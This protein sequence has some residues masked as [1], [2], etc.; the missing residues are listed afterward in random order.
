MARLFI[1]RFLRQSENAK[2][3]PGPGEGICR[4]CEKAGGVRNE[5]GEMEALQSENAGE[6]CF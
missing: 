6:A 5:G 4:V 2:N 3:Q 1:L